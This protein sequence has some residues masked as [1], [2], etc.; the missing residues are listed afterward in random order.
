PKTDILDVPTGLVQQLIGVYIG[1]GIIGLPLVE[2]SWK[3]H[4]LCLQIL[5]QK[6]HAHQDPHQNEQDG[7]I[8]LHPWGDLEFGLLNDLL[9]TGVSDQSPGL[10]NAVH[11]MVARIDAGGTVHAFQLGPITDVYPG[12]ADMDALETVDAVPM[13]QG[14]AVLSLAEHLT[15]LLPFPPLVVVGHHDGLFVQ[16]HPLQPAVG[17]GDDAYLFPEP[18]EDEI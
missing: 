6:E 11:D 5:S 1:Y 12:G 16:E 18:G 14:V 15:A 2:L 3:A 13:A 17:A 9:L 8:A 4:D 10:G 7:G